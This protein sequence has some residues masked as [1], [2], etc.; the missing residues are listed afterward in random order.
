MRK[1]VALLEKT[2]NVK[3]SSYTWNALNAIISALQNPVILLVMTRTNGVFDAGVFSIA[4]A[5]ATLMLYV[6]LYGL[7]RFQSSDLDEKYSF[8]EY[9]GMRILTCSL[10]IFVSAIYCIYGMIFTSYSMEKALVIF[11][12]CIVKVCQAYSDVY[13]G[14]MQQKGR[15]DV[16]TKSSS[17]RYTFEMAA[18]VVLLLVT[19]N[20]LLSTAAFMVA[21]II[22]L[23][24]TSVNAGRNY[25]TYRP[26]FNK[27]KIKGLA[28]EGFPLFASLF[29]NMYISNAPK[30]AIDAFLTEETQAIYNMI[31]MPAF[32]VML[33]ANFIF[34]PILTTYA[35]LWLAE[36]REQIGKLKKEIK[37]Q[38]LVILGLTILG[39][40]IA[41]TI[42]IPVLAFIFGVS[43]SEYKAE[44]CVVMLGGGALAYATYF[45]TV[46]T[47]I[48]MQKTLIV[49]YG[50]VALAAKLLSRFFVLTYGIMGAASMYAFLMG[51]LA[52]MLF[53]IT[54]YGIR[55]ESLRLK[56]LSQ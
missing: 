30:Y 10:M 37:K 23:L 39:L 40:T 52:V 49:C 2:N 32:A 13:H 29:L 17:V 47:I 15:L 44:L 3:R 55:K 12:I 7:R 56:K 27:A 22:G 9:H 54:V 26:S 38:M 14:C 35:E 28:I 4:F 43:L 41:A 50:I 53:V 45:S 18:Y 48:R 36:K 16:A 42:G 21:S 20:L 24:L 5:I 1:I 6:G 11:M 34:N 25:C 31:F 19:H 46:I 51:V 33:I 8:S